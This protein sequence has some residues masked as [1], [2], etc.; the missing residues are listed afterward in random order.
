M[1][2]A[3]FTTLL[4]SVVEKRVSGFSSDVIYLA[5]AAAAAASAA[6]SNSSYSRH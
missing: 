4:F 6:V 3:E 1:R 5:V 2:G